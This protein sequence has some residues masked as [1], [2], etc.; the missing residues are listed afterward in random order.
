MLPDQAKTRIEIVGDAEVLVLRDRLIP[1]V[2]F[3]D[4]LGVVPTYPIRTVGARSIA[5]LG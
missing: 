1:L 2:R 4:L 3:A 5:A